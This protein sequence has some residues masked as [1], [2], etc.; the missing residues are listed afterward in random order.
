MNGQ[1]PIKNIFKIVLCVNDKFESDFSMVRT[2]GVAIRDYSDVTA[3][4]HLKAK[5]IEA[6]RTAK[7]EHGINESKKISYFNEKQW[8]NLF[9]NQIYQIN[10]VKDT[11]PFSHVLIREASEMLDD[12]CG[13][14]IPQS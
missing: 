4:P 3:L 9:A 13:V 5:V 2:A 10:R 14:I 12:L 1:N 7:K 8:I 6:V 11:D